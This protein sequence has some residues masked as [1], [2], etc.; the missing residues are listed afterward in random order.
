M[1]PIDLARHPRLEALL[2]RLLDL[3]TWI[4]CLIIGIGILAA[5]SGAVPAVRA[6]SYIIAAGVALFIALPI[7]RVALMAIVFLTERDYMFCA[8][9]TSVLLIIALGA[10]VSIEYSS[11]TF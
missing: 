7:L 8:I 6:G 2:A 4:A 11:V 5:L 3:G 10:A 9:A 1:T